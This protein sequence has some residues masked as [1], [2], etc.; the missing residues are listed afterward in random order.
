MRTFEKTQRHSNALIIASAKIH[1]KSPIIAIL[2]LSQIKK[3]TYG[4]FSSQKSLLKGLYRNPP[5]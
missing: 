5:L 1:L 2:A 4:S 3:E